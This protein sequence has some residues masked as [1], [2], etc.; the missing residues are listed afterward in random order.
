[1][2]NA[3]FSPFANEKIKVLKFQ[4]N[5]IRTSSS[6]KFTPLALLIFYFDVK[7]P[8]ICS[9]LQLLFTVV[10]SRVLQIYISKIRVY[11][12]IITLV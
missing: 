9:Q 8:L 4:R 5:F 2:P 10:I 3:Y 7:I 1:M 12:S 6:E 11:G